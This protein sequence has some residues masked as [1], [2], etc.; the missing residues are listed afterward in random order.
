MA[1]IFSE[2][3][4][5]K[6]ATASAAEETTDDPVV[7]DSNAE[8]VSEEDTVAAPLG[9]K[10]AKLRASATELDRLNLAAKRK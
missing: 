3:L 2:I 8:E 1:S 10:P 5:G 6:A 9:V 4:A 7:E